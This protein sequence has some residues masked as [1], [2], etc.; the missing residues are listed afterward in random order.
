MS[1]T[2]REGTVSR[3]TTLVIALLPAALL[4]CLLALFAWHALSPG[5]A[6]EPSFALLLACTLVA[7]A[8]SAWT[9]LLAERKKAGLTERR[10]MQRELVEALHTAPSPER[11]YHGY[12]FL[13]GELGRDPAMQ[14]VLHLAFSRE[15]M[16][17]L[18]QQ[19]S[20]YLRAGQFAE[21]LA[22]L[23]EMEWEWQEGAG[24]SFMPAARTLAHH[25]RRPVHGPSPEV[26]E[27][28]LDG[29][30]CAGIESAEPV[31]AW[32]AR[33]QP[34]L[35]TVEKVLFRK[36]G[37]AGRYLLHR[38]AE[39]QEELRSQVR[40]WEQALALPARHNGRHA[41]LW[42]RERGESLVVQQGVE[43]LGL[44]LN[45]FGPEK[46]EQDP[47]LPD[48][49]YRLSPAWEEATAR[50]PALMVV[51]AGCGRSALIW[52]MRYESCLV[53]SD[54][55]GTFVVH[56]PVRACRSTSELLA[57]LRAALIDAW[58][59]SLARDPYGLLG[60]DEADRQE[61]SELLLD[62]EG[63]LQAL[64]ARLAAAGLPGSDPDG[65]FLLES[66]EAVA[67]SRAGHPPAEQQAPWGDGGGP[68]NL[69]AIAGLLRDAFTVRELR[70]FCQEHPAFR[71][72]L[73]EFPDS[74]LNDMVY[75]LLDYCTRRDL[76]AELLAQVR[77]HNPRQYE[78][79]R[80]ELEEGAA[81]GRASDALPHRFLLRP[82]GTRHT[83]LL[84]DL[85]GEE[86]EAARIAVDAFFVHWLP[87][88]VAN[89]LLP[90]LFLAREPGRCP[91]PPVHVCW[92]QRALAALLRHRLERAG[93]VLHGHQRAMDGWIEDVPDAGAAMVQAAGGCPARLIRMGNA[94]VRR[95][96]QTC[97]PT[98]EE[99]RQMISGV[100]N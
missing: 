43:R 53:G 50:Q 39:R 13:H 9:G 11:A 58:C 27:Q 55:E 59:C 56:I 26:V 78:G 94:L 93:L 2:N 44:T 95:M 14:A 79:H 42:P 90:K 18:R 29:F 65:R 88:L 80:P 23:D 83:F 31:L 61:A 47:L 76:C 4:L 71:P 45:P 84:V 19:L 98:R 22:F 21:A 52:M 74:G 3:A 48:L 81:P 8:S 32:L 41:A 57:A 17:Y 64:A 12:L 100:N 96:A 10:L 89:N 92:D 7:V 69:S 54:L 68:A 62:T 38:W 86:Q 20:R 82:Y 77:L 75:V 6:V 60:L 49:F 33:A 1:T 16:P 66:L 5:R 91:V 87:C 36:G 24:P 37:A 63:G 70:R 67:H 51:P 85:W 25:L 34:D 35:T 30:R 40:A 28:V 46:A 73:L 97:P 15:W 99:F 72:V